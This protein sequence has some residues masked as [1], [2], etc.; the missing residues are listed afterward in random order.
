MLEA[1]PS[2]CFPTNFKYY[3]T[4]DILNTDDKPGVT[5]SKGHSSVLSFNTPQPASPSPQP[6]WCSPHGSTV[7]EA[8]REAAVHIYRGVSSVGLMT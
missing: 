8:A 3:G 6:L 5:P 4:P 7:L 2:P 1:E